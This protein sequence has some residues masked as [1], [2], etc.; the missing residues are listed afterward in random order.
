MA[1]SWGVRRLGDPQITEHKTFDHHGL[2][3]VRGDATV[4]RRAPTTKYAVGGR[5]GSLRSVSES[6]RRAI[7]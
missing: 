1:Q 3:T 5:T 2:P 4:R 6:V 7:S